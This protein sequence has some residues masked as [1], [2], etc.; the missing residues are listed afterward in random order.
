MHFT[1][2]RLYSTQNLFLYLALV[3]YVYSIPRI[4]DHEDRSRVVTRVLRT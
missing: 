2:N 3:I 1:I 4:K